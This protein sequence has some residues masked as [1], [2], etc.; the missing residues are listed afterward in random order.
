VAQGVGL[1]EEVLPRTDLLDHLG[2]QGLGVRGEAE[3]DPPDQ[4][5]Q[6]GVEQHRDGRED[7]AARAETRTHQQLRAHHPRGCCGQPAL[8][9][10]LPVRRPRSGRERA[11]PRREPDVTSELHPSHLEQRTRLTA[12][13]QGHGFHA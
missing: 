11:A 5:E 9:A 1:A 7:L 3:R 8:H 6:L 4:V 2:R 13:D 12:P 10:R